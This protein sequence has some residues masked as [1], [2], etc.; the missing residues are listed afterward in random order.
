MSPATL[1]SPRFL[2]APLHAGDAGDAGDRAL[3]C[4]LYTSAEV[5]ARIM[6][7]LSPAQA[8]AAFERTCRHNARDHPGHRHW[9]VREKGSG[10]AAGIV[11]LLRDG[12]AVEIGGVLLP[13]W[14]RRGVSREAYRS[15]IDHAFGTMDADVVFGEREDDDHARVIDRLFAPL[16]LVRVA[17][18]GRRPGRCRWELRR[19]G[20]NPPRRIG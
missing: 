4:A 17:G 8:L 5:M 10:R 9:S 11:G 13:A 1:E 6:P 3:Y 14:W 7:P 12:D 20:W 18:G 19:S 2:L 16:G 15:V